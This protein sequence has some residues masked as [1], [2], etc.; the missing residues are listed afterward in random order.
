MKNLN[1]ESLYKLTVFLVFSVLLVHILIVGQSI[2][3]PLLIAFFIAFLL[4]PL[5]NFLERY[6]FP[7]PLSAITCIII[8]IVLLAG[9]FTLFGS[10]VNTF[11]KDLDDITDKI[12]ELKSRLPEVVQTQLDDISTEEII[13]YAQ[14][15]SSNI[16]SSLTNVLSGFTLLLIIPIY[17]A[18]ILIYRN[19]LR[20]F[21]L[22]VFNVD[23]NKTENTSKQNEDSPKGIKVLIPRIKKII[24]KYIVGMF[25]VICVLFVLNSIA[26]FSLGI[27]HAMLFAAIAAVLNIIPFVGPLIGST[28]PVMFA[29]ITKDSL[30]YPL[31]VMA[32]F[33][34]IQ[35][36]ESNFLTPKIVGSNVSLNPLVTLITLFVGAS[37]WGIVGMI[38]FIPMVAIIKEILRNID[39]LEPYAY[40]LGNEDEEKSQ[41]EF[42]KK[43]VIKLKDKLKK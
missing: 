38:L 30:F 41:K 24:Q 4:I 25:Y 1:F 22:K 16:F 19:L 43:A 32:S 14:S 17:I 21:L 12:S 29:L 15:N 7:R 3:V 20:T 35:S 39:G 10:Q 37:I 8:T 42:I 23:G 31:A 34:I 9:V 6:K 27:Q 28:L 40:L 26:L 36:I 18:M 33:I 13:G 5:A 11:V 2:I